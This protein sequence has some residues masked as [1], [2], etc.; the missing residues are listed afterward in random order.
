M[1]EAGVL[2]E[3]ERL[4]LLNGLLVY[5]HP[6]PSGDQYVGHST[7]HLVAVRLLTALTKR[8]D[9]PTRHL[10]IQLPIVIPDY[11]EPEPDGSVILGADRTFLTRKPNPADVASVIEV[12]HTSV[13][14]DSGEKLQAY[15]TAGIAQYVIVNLPREGIEV[16]SEPD[17]KG[18]QYKVKATIRRDGSFRLYLGL[19]E[20]LEVV[21][22]ELLP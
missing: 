18:G 12:A 16:Y 5:K 1:L 17:S 21:G 14:R 11:D 2:R 22:D 13:L 4:E 10:Q 6:N 8:I 7:E 3:P 20:F 19:N 9:T 15:A